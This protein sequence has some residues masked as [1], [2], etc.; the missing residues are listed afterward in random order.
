MGPDGGYTTLAACEAAHDTYNKG[1][2]VVTGDKSCAS[3]TLADWQKAKAAEKPLGV[4]DEPPVPIKPK[5]GAVALSDDY[6]LLAP[7][8]TLTTFNTKNIGEYF[9]MM[10]MLA[11]GL[12]A[13]LAVLVIIFSAIQYMGTES[14]F[15]KTEAKSKIFGAIL[16]LLIAL[17]SYAILNTISP[18]LTGVNGLSVDQASIILD[19]EPMTSDDPVPPGAKTTE[20]TAGIDANNKPP[21][22]K[23]IAEKI[24]S[25]L[26]KAKTEGYNI[27][28]YG[29][30]NKQKQE[31]LRSSNCGGSANIY[32]PAA[33]CKP[34]T[35]IPGTSM[36]ESGLAFDLQC[37]GVSIRSKQNKCFL[38]LAK[39][40]GGYGLKNLSSEPWHWST[41]GH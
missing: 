40:A 5:S 12:C 7:I 35:A 19:G 41:T 10:F 30:R 22:C 1:N 21:A 6:K 24:N 11:I 38:W 2:G 37:D 29:F 31:Q 14:I 26:A 34:L 3:G 17:G 32:N 16:G 4:G 39:N 13:A 15:G 25:M 18:D 28:G 23:T 36:H 9:N 33:K 8:G 20:C 27:T